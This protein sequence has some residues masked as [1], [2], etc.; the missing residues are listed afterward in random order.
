MT[1]TTRSHSDPLAG[2]MERSRLA[3]IEL[4]RIRQMLDTDRF[5]QEPIPPAPVKVGVPQEIRCD[6]HLPDQ[7]CC[8]GQCVKEDAHDGPCVCA[9]GTRYGSYQEVF[10][11]R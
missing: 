6:V 10:G 3:T 4:K 8:A 2:L 7:S 5:A 9:C 11:D 1:A